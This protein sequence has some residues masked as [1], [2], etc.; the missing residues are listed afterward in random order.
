MSDMLQQRS[1]R[2]EMRGIANLL[3]F[4]A[5]VASVT[6]EVFLHRQFGPRY[7]GGQAAAGL[8]VVPVFGA[9]LYPHHDQRP[10]LVFVGLFL[11]GCA[12][13]RV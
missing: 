1:P 3:M 7:I 2:Q 4:V 13:A 9:L 5:R 6:V 8:L 12:S 11:L 10:L